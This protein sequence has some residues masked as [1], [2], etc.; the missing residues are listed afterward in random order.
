MES[1]S[2]RYLAR[3]HVQRLSGA[4]H[5]RLSVPGG[6]TFYTTFIGVYFIN[7]FNFTSGNIGDFLAYVGLWIVISQGLILRKLT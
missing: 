6:F 3:L 5:H 2:Q 1:V 4:L 7:K